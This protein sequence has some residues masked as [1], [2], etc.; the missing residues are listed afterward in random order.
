LGGAIGNVAS[1][2]EGANGEIFVVDYRGKVVQL[3]SPVPQPPTWVMAVLGL[4]F[5]LSRVAR[6]KP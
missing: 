2:G 3:L 5:V 1:F 4:G 6:Q